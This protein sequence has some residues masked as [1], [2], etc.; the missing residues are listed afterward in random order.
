MR[1]PSHTSSRPG[2]SLMEVLVALTIFLFSLIALSALVSFATDQ[3]IDIQQRNLAGRLC[4]SKLNEV[5][6][7]VLQPTSQ[8]GTFDEEPDYNWSVTADQNSSVSGL[9]TVTVTVS[10]ERPDGSKI[11]VELSQMMVDP[12]IQGSTQDTT[13]VTGTDSTSGS[14]STNPSNP[15]TPTPAAPAAPAAGGTTPPKTGG[16]TTPAAPKTTTP[17]PAPAPAPKATTPATTPKAGTKG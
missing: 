5:L 4:E 8:D 7:G 16:T 2:L 15:T 10:R 14:G 6:S 13:A 3:A 17:A 11:T 12:S 1:L 9:W